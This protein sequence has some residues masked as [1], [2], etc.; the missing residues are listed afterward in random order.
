MFPLTDKQK[1]ITKADPFS[2]VYCKIQ[3]SNWHPTLHY[4]VFKDYEKTQFTSITKRSACATD[5]IIL[6]KSLVSLLYCG[7]IL[8]PWFGLDQIREKG[9]CKSIKY[10]WLITLSL[11]E[12]ISILM[13]VVSFR[14]TCPIDRAQ[15]ISNWIYVDGNEGNHMLC[16]QT[17]P[18]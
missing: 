12:N 1:K 11:W 2:Q 3:L 16:Q 18:S 9:K 4:G 6:W 17:H 7:G 13:G 15:W 14:M 8:L 5:W 10:L